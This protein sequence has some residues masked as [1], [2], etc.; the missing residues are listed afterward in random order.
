[1][2]KPP[3]PPTAELEPRQPDP[4]EAMLDEILWGEAIPEDDTVEI[5]ADLLA[6]HSAAILEAA[7]LDLSS[8]ATG[9]ALRS[10]PYDED[11]I[12]T[13]TVRYVGDDSVEVSPVD[14]PTLDLPTC[15]PIPPSEDG[16]E[17]L[18]PDEL[19]E[20]VD[21]V[22]ILQPQSLAADMLEPDPVS[23]PPEDFVEIVDPEPA[24]VE[25][26]YGK[27]DDGGLFDAAFAERLQADPVMRRAEWGEPE[28]ISR[29]EYDLGESGEAL[30]SPSPAATELTVAEILAPLEESGEF[31]ELTTTP[32]GAADT[33]DGRSYGWRDFWR[34]ALSLSAG[35]GLVSV[36][37]WSYA[38][39]LPL[40][41]TIT[42]ATVGLIIAVLS[43]D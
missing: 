33:A 28:R 42:L 16:I 17:F 34:T 21:P 9:L 22:D 37:G 12:P 15:Q 14:I 32:E 7:G 1:V 18:E 11:R 23:L 41:L 8:E 29:R 20:I 30:A 38:V 6:E 31:A 26:L 35:I 5:G 36:S 39:G 25:L 19:V 10:D 27:L 3:E 40:W 24:A 43:A 2:R 13:A 4:I